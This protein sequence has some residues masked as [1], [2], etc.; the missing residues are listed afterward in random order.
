MR[1]CAMLRG[2]DSKAKVLYLRELTEGERER[3]KG[4]QRKGER[5]CSSS[6]VTAST[7]P[8]FLLLLLFFDSRMK[9]DEIYANV[10]G[11]KWRV[12]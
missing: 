8:F 10:N 3:K 11:E 4:E 1:M 7:L 2:G 9:K 5:A 12:V 6:N